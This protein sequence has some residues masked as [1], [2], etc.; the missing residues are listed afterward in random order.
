LGRKRWLVLGVHLVPHESATSVFHVC[1]P[2]GTTE[3]QHM[4][5]IVM[6]F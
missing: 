6:V 3:V 5:A 4:L 2:A 1:A